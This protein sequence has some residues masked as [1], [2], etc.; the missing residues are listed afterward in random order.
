V[1]YLQQPHAGPLIAQPLVHVEQARHNQLGTWKLAADAGTG[2]EPHLSPLIY[3]YCYCYCYMVQDLPEHPVGSQRGSWGTRVIVRIRVNILNTCLLTH[4]QA[5]QSPYSLH[6]EPSVSSSFPTCSS[7][8]P[9]RSSYNP[10]CTWNRPA[11]RSLAPGNCLLLMLAAPAAA[12][13]TGCDPYKSTSAS[14]GT[15]ASS[16]S[17]Q[18]GTRMLHVGDWAAAP[19]QHCVCCM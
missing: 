4:K 7:L 1:W 15:S 14:T 19:D 6:P 16:Y 17:S 3:C 9:G 18:Q 13:D 8:M 12:E 2:R 11:I 5:H 10:L